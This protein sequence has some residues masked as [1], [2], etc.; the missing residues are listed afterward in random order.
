[1]KNLLIAALAAVTIVTSAFSPDPNEINFAA[2]KNFKAEFAKAAQVVWTQKADFVK[3]EFTL[4]NV[5]MEAFY[6]AD[7]DMIA[8]SKYISLDELPVKAKRT[9]AKLYT[10]YTVKEAIRYEGVDEAAYYI[11]AENE[12]ESVIVK[13]YDNSHLSVFQK[14]KK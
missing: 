10:D 2:Q 11:S 1:M 4:N 13:V 3:A 7:G 6:N 5:K 9:F 8:T 12:K 14:T